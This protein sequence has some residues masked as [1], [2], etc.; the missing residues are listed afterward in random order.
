MQKF[1]LTAIAAA[2]LTACSLA[3]KYERPEAPVPS[4]FDAAATAGTQQTAADAI[5]WRDFFTDPYLQ[6]LIAGALQNNRDL[7]V[8]ALNVEAAQAQY[9]IRRADLVPAIDASGSHTS[10]RYPADLSSTGDSYVARSYNVGVGITSYELDLFGRVRSLKREALEQYLSLA[11]TQRSTQISLVAQVAN[12]YLT[13]LSDEE[14]LRVTQE[15][16]KSQ[17]SSYDLSK[18]RFDAGAASALDLRQAQTTLETARANLAQ[19]QRQVAMDRNALSVLV[20]GPLPAQMPPAEQFAK[21]DFLA[22]LPSGVPSDVL[23]RRPDVLA[24]E[25]DLKGANANIGAARAA[26]F[27]QITLTGSYGTASSE[28]DGLFD[29][30]SSAWTFAPQIT[31]PIFNAGANQANLDLAHVQKNIYVA[32]Y[33]KAIQ[34]AFQEVD[35]ALV[36]RATYDD[37]LKAQQNLV[38]A[39]QDAYDLAQARFKSGVDD[40]LTVLD[41]QRSLYSAQQGYVAVKLARLQNLVTLY[42]ALGGGWNEHTLAQAQRQQQAV[43]A[44]QVDAASRP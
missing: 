16:L 25:H 41:S 10:E 23:T 17:Q 20:G 39:T 8:A 30:G 31:L 42:K 44:E 12:A 18:Q 13:L 26:F 11:E 4:N 28:L 27:P 35:D 7:R 6:Q 3:P 32:Q 24:A 37:Q 33:E 9:R 19:Y 36:S 22:E 38:Q 29:K 1:V 14:L 15:T 2:A 40:Y 34:T 5:G 43:T 21:Q